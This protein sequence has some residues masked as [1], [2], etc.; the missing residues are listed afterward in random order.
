MITARANEAL[1]YI[2]LLEG[3]DTDTSVAGTQAYNFPDNFHFIHEVRYKGRRLKPI[4]FRQWAS[5]R[6]E[7]TTVTGRPTSFVIWNNQVLLIPIPADSADTIT[8]YGYKTHPEID[9]VT[10]TTIDIP[11]VLHPHLANGVIADMYAKD[12]NDGMFSSYEALWRTKSIPA[13]EMYKAK[14]SSGGQFFVIGDSDTDTDT[15]EGIF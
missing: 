8:F 2:G 3:T 1:S 15:S 7:D 10:Q 13:F 12:L 11:A 4:T 14:Y 9:G 6:D 5:Y